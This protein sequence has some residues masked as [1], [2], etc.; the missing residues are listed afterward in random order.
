MKKKKIAID[1]L[2]Q[3]QKNDVEEEKNAMDGIANMT[4]LPVME[5]DRKIL[6][7]HVGK[8]GGATLD[9]IFRS[10]CEYKSKKLRCLS[11]LPE[12]HESV[13]SH[14]TKYTVH[15]KPWKKLRQFADITSYLFTVRNP[16]DRA[17]SAFNMDHLRNTDDLSNS[18]Y[19]LYLKNIFYTQCFPIIEDIASVLSDSL[20]H[21]KTKKFEVHEV[22]DPKFK[23]YP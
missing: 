16:I 18:P 8:T 10:N 1:D 20:N 4:R 13:L 3:A 6:Y 14:L 9:K 5:G 7:L 22:Y 2:M 19:W 11:E 23:C 17:I 21:G 12:H 15:V